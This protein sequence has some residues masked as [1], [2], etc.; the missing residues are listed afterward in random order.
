MS[1]QDPNLVEYQD[2]LRALLGEGYAEFKIADCT[3]AQRDL[4]ETILAR[5]K[6]SLK[7]SK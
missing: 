3:E 1:E 7:K 6:K 2:I 4:L 5:L